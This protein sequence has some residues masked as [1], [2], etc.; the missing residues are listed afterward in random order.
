MAA[1]ALVQTSKNQQGLALLVLVILI[2]LAF[3]TYSLSGLS[4][5]QVKAEQVKKTRIALKKAKQALLSYAVNYPEITPAN[6][7][8]GYLPCPDLND[9][10]VSLVNNCKTG[11]VP[12]VGRLPWVTLGVGDL[13]DSDNEKLWYAVS[14]NYDYSNSPTVNKINTATTGTITVKDS[15]NNMIYDGTSLDAIVAVIIAPGEALTRDDGVVQNRSAANVNAAIHYLDIH[16]ASAEDN[17]SFQH[18]SLD[19][20]IEGEIT[21]GAGNVI[22][23]D[24]FIVIT[25]G[26]IMDLIHKRVSGEIGNVINNY[27]AICND[28]PE[29]A[30]FDATGVGPFNSVALSQQGVLPV[31]TALPVNWNTGCA[32]GI[33]LPLWVQSE[34]WHMNTYYQYSYTKAVPLPL[35]GIPAANCV[36]PP[37]AVVAPAVECMTVN[38]TDLPID[39]KRALIIFAGR[40]LAGQVR[41]AAAG[42]ADYF[43]NE[44]ND[45]DFVFD[46]AET[47]DYVWVIAP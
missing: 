37:P 35:P 24:Q 45:G 43:E 11:G 15:S 29:A 47:E 1:G 9:T 28:Y 36:T 10:G 40:A 2:I 14:D 17:A 13:R 16:V 46:A 23:N 38:N 39:N 8:P 41:N 19:G 4:L 33:S 18:G 27:F 22:V 32:A 12:N 20:F 30:L 3:V 6:R 5:N 7:G 26:E 31:G 25:Y 44:N 42:M 34:G 21:D